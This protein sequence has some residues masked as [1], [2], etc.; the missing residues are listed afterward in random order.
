MTST[1][2]IILAKSAGYCFGVQRAVDTVLEQV[3]KHGHE[4]TIYTLGPLIHNQQVI[5]D[6][7][8][9]GV[10]TLPD[11]GSLDTIG[12]GIVVIRSHGVSRAVMQMLEDKGIRYVDATCP[13]VERIHKIVREE[14]QA[15]HRVIVVGN[16][17]HP[18]V[19]GICGWCEQ[20]PTVIRSAGEAQDFSDEEQRLISVVAQTTFQKTNF[21][22]IVEILRH[23]GYNV[24]VLDTICSATLERQKEAAEIASKVDV[25]LVVGDVHSSNTQ[26]LFEICNTCCSN[27]YY[28]QV[29][30]DLDLDQVMTVRTVGITAGASTPN[31]IIEEVQNHVRRK[32]FV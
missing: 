9:K 12:D 16:P 8:Q 1:P 19:R 20:Q 25:M 31:Y 21:T 28:V 4:R 23:K 30:D 5:E 6:L 2:Q 17:D 7:A 22:E 3:R 10:V 11:E 32:D 29:P 13:F 24:N 14:E 26:K 18:E 27:T 15:G